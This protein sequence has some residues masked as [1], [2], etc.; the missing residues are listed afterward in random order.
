MGLFSSRWQEVYFSTNMESFFRGQNIL[1][2]HGIPFRTKTEN[3]TLRES[4]NNLGGRSPMQTRVRFD[5]ESGDTYRIFVAE[6]NAAS[7][8]FLLQNNEIN[9]Q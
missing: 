7:A 3:R 8:R 1:R 9:S 6:E 4:R 2:E 5:S